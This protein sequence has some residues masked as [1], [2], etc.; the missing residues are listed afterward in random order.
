MNEILNV[1]PLRMLYGVAHS[2]LSYRKAY[3]W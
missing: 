1:I 3:I 2:R